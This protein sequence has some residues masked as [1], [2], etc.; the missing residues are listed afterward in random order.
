MYLMWIIHNT[1]TESID[2]IG[3]GK[4]YWNDHAFHMKERYQA[5]GICFFMRTWSIECLHLNVFICTESE[6]RVQRSLVSSGFHFIKQKTH[7]KC[8]IFCLWRF[9]TVPN[10]VIYKYFWKL[11]L[12]GMEWMFAFTQNRINIYDF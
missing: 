12:K 4:S 2:P 1:H 3:L 7:L 11:K 8:V 10:N 6:A 5:T 9:W